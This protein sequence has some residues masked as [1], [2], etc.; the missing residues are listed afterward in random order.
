LMNEPGRGE[1]VDGEAALA[2]GEAER[3]TDMRLAGAGRSGDI[4]PGIRTSRVE[5]T[6]GTIRALVR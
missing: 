1:E 6:I 3:Q 2:R 5:S 4:L